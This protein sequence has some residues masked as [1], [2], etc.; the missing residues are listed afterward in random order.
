MPNMPCLIR[1]AASA[2]VMGNHTS[3]QDLQRVLMLLSS[4]GMPCSLL[5]H[6]THMSMV[7]MSIPEDSASNKGNLMLA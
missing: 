4:V 3:E 6:V 5:L 2:F 7:L 1:Q